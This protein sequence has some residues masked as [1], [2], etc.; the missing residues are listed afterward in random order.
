MDGS[1]LVLCPHLNSLVF[2]FLVRSARIGEERILVRIFHY[3][4]L[5]TI[6]LF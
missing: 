4:K 5:K 1:K 3:A 6:A 2:D